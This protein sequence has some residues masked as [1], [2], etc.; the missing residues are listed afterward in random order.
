MDKALAA[1]MMAYALLSMVVDAMRLVSPAFAF[2]LSGAHLLR[3][4]RS[5]K[6]ASV[7]SRPATR[8]ATGA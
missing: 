5:L 8:A 7:P 3:P 4:R 2:G 6:A 1:G